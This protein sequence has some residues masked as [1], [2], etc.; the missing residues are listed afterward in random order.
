M[1]LDEALEIYRQPKQR[2]RRA[3]ATAPLRE[4]GADAAT[5]KPMVI[6]DGR[7]GPYVTDGETN[8][9]LRKGDSV[10]AITDERA[11]EL[12][13]ER[14]AKAPAPK[15]ARSR[16]AAE[17]R[18]DEGRREEGAEPKA[19]AQSRTGARRGR[20]AQH[21]G[22][23]HPRAAVRPGTCGVP[24]AGLLR[25]RQQRLDRRRHPL[26]V[27]PP[28]RGGRRLLH[29]QA[30]LPRPRRLP[31]LAPPP[32]P[33]R[34]GPAT[35]SSSSV[36]L[37]R[38]VA[39]QD[40]ALRPLLRGQLVAARR[41]ERLRRLG[42]LLGLLGDDLPTS[43]SSSSRACLPATSTV[44]TAVSVIRSVDLTSSSRDFIA[45]GEVGPQPLLEGA[46]AAPRTL[47]VPALA[48]RALPHA[49]TLAA[50]VR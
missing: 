26:A 13:A 7:F 12:L 47:A 38:Q 27:R 36:E 24:G 16:P 17:G 1:T 11:S 14:R 48:R 30:H 3:A 39:R 28:R 21:D 43:A 2:G 19:A 22:R 23:R 34:P 25:R 9:S 29:H 44:W 49:A 35:A 10:E 41:R 31:G 5:G 37:L 33:P 4:L 42:P 18:R 20:R 50:P 32:P 46:H 6:K 40:L 8:A 45:G 15:R